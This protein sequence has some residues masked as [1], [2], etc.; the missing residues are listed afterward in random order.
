MANQYGIHTWIRHGKWW[1]KLQNMTSA[2]HPAKFLRSSST[3]EHVGLTSK[4]GGFLREMGY[5]QSS[6]ILDGDFPW[7]KPFI[8][9]RISHFYRIVQIKPIIFDG[10]FPCIQRAIGVSPQFYGKPPDISRQDTWSPGNSIPPSQTSGGRQTSPTP[11]VDSRRGPWRMETLK[12]TRW[13]RTSY[14]PWEIYRKYIWKLENLWEIYIYI[15][16][17]GL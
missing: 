13:C 12:V 9:A 5:P 1:V 16:Q 8:W 4:K 2:F 6:S 3:A 7:N 14:Y 15:Y 10:D 11:G 17:N